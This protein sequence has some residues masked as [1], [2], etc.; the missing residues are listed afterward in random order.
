MSLLKT[1]CKWLTHYQMQC[2]MV[3]VGICSHAQQLS[4]QVVVDSLLCGSESLWLHAQGLS[5]YEAVDLM[6]QVFMLT[7]PVT[8]G[9]TST[10]D[11]Y[12]YNAIGQLS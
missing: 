5:G 3:R 11:L 12:K 9:Y 2:Y 8:S 10:V 6:L 1:T 4:G 7:R